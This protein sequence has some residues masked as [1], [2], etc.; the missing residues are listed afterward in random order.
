MRSPSAITLTC[1]RAASVRVLDGVDDQVVEDMLDA[2]A[3]DHDR[4]GGRRRPSAVSVT[5]R[6]LR[7]RLEARDRFVDEL[8]G[9][10]GLEVELDAALFDPGQVEQVVDHRQDAVGVLAGRQQQLDLLGSERADHLLEQ[11]VDRPS[12]R[13]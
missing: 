8:G 4:R 12:A 5:P 13:W 6:A 10:D 1:D 11:Q 3:I 9:G 7:L 2:I